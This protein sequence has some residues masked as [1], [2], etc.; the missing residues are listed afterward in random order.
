MPEEP[1]LQGHLLL[2]LFVGTNLCHLLNA[3]GTLSLD[4]PKETICKEK[5]QL[6][7]D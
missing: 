7:G 1:V 5:S 3:C 4:H 6:H 2:S